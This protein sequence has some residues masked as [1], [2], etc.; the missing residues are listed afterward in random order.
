[1]FFALYVC[2]E[3]KDALSYVDTDG[4]RIEFIRHEQKLDECDPQF[5]EETKK[6]VEDFKEGNFPMIQDKIN[7]YRKA[8]FHHMMYRVSYETFQSANRNP[9]EWKDFLQIFDHKCE[10]LLEGFLIVGKNEK[11]ERIQDMREQLFLQLMN[12]MQEQQAK[13]FRD[14]IDER[15][16]TIEWFYSHINLYFVECFKSM[17][18]DSKHAKITEF[19]LYFFEKLVR[20]VADEAY[21]K[22]TNLRQQYFIEGTTSLKEDFLQ[23]DDAVKEEKINAILAILEEASRKEKKKSSQDKEDD[24]DE[25]ASQNKLDLV[26][27]CNIWRFPTQEILMWHAASKAP[28]SFSKSSILIIKNMSFKKTFEH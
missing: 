21:A 23:I 1:M 17:D 3:G 24:S 28:K 9:D 19:T 22:E 12:V 18:E 25:Q 14:S 4:Y 8:L 2:I 5:K 20:V 27:S 26:A 7:E 11:E 13:R 16:Q 6:I 10:Q 15:K